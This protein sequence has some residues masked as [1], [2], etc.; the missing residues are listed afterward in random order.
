[1][2]TNYLTEYKIIQLLKNSSNIVTDD[3]DTW[4]GIC[5]RVTDGGVI[6]NHQPIITLQGGVLWRHAN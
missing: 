1:M 2:F 4:Q 5:Y 3:T 6:H